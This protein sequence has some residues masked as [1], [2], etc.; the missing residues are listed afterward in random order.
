MIGDHYL[1]IQAGKD[2]NCG[3]TIGVLGD[4]M[5]ERFNLCEPDVYVKD[6]REL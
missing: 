1:D 5:K 4:H 6:L 2:A 3:L